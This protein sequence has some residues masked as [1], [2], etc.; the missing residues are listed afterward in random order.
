MVA[1]YNLTNLYSIDFRLESWSCKDDPTVKSIG[2]LA[3]DLDSIPR[4]CMAA[5]NSL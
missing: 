5:H 2:V 1:I 4:T 3:E